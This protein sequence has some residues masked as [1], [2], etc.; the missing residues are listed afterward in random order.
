[1]GR[2][3]S[4]D[5]SIVMMV[6]KI[7]K[8]EGDEP[9]YLEA[10]DMASFAHVFAPEAGDKFTVEWLEMTEAAFEALPQFEHIRMAQRWAQLINRTNDAQAKGDF[11]AADRISD[12][13]EHLRQAIAD[14]GYNVQDLLDGELPEG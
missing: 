3:E 2:W 11:N 12:E 9:Y 10:S 7:T 1:M 5:R 4:G 14:M 13:A 8:S 6:A